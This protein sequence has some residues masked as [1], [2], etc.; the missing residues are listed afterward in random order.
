MGGPPYNWC[1]RKPVLGMDVST[2][3]RA[4]SS[5]G[6]LSPAISATFPLGRSASLLVLTIFWLAIYVGGMFSPALLDDA[7]SVHAEAAREMVLR[8]D[9]VTLHIDGLRY[10]EKAPL[11]YWGMAGSFKLFGV[12]EWSARLPLMLG[13]LALMF[14]TYGLGKY[15]YGEA[16]GFYSALVLGTAVGT[17][18]FTR[19]L[20]PDLLVGL[21]LTLGFYFFLRSLEEDTPSRLTCWGFAATCALNV[22]TKGLIGLVFPA[23]TI[24]LYLI[25]TGKLRH[26]LKLR[27]VSSTLV[28]MVLAAPWHILAALRNPTQGS[29]RGF[30][31]FY[32]VNEHFLRY[33]NKR[34]PRDYDTVPLLVF[35]ALLL[36]WMLP[37]TMF[38]PQALRKVPMRWRELRAPLERRQ[39]ANLLFLLWALV[40][41]SF[42]SFSTRQE[43]YTIPALPGLAL[44]IGGWLGEESAGSAQSYMHRSGRTSSAVLLG[45]G[46]VIFA[47][48]MFLFVQSKPPAPGTDLADLLRM[49][50]AQEYTLS[51]GHISDLTPQSLGAFRAPLLGVSL[52]FLLGT[53]ANWFLRRLGS[54]FRGNLALAAMMVVVLLC[55]HSALVTF[56]PILSSKNLALAIQKHYRAGDVVV[57]DDE[58]EQGSTLNFYLGVPV[59]I[60]HERTANLYY[61]SLFPDAPHVFETQ[62]SFHALWSGPARIFLWTGQDIP[63]DLEG[64]R[65]Y[66][67]ARDGG[68]SILTNHEFER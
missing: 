33:L 41:V 59:R 61:G 21:W 31:W 44:L 40:V 6:K 23:A 46:L 8:H 65:F 7:D 25:L 14:A 26:L 16:G 62:A 5:Q 15:S 1:F 64:A 34:I 35:W 12:S 37:W 68:K 38:L 29:V 58:Y 55:V 36:L 42:F 52:T 19:I 11:L 17:Y 43:Y 39:R 51:F 50:N 24:G 53:G 63:R 67:L 45:V 54:P 2:T 13:V 56:S 60:L 66:V 10:L 28:F 57:I 32:F 4:P 18:L 20:I 48:G 27:P 30:L 22:L 47:L 3:L 9:W 49:K